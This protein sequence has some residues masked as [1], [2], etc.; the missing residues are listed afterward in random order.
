MI[1][2]E[3]IGCYRPCANPLHYYQLNISAFSS[4]DLNIR[5][6]CRALFRLRRSNKLEE[7]FERL[8]LLSQISVIYCQIHLYDYSS[9]LQPWGL[10]EFSYGQDGTM[11]LIIQLTWARNLNTK[12]P[13]IRYPHVHIFSPIILWTAP[14]VCYQNLSVSSTVAACIAHTPRPT[15]IAVLKFGGFV[16]LKRRKNTGKI[17]SSSNLLGQNRQG[18]SGC[19]ILKQQEGNM[20]RIPWQWRELESFMSRYEHR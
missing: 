19:Q 20:N 18:E 2:V 3:W 5:C 6:L 9:I 8:D 1:T 11:Q 13:I 7:S 17:W 14:H 10:N 16:S 12:T 15:L 4:H